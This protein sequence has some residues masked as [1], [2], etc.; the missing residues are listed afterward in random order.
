MLQLA[1]LLKDQPQSE[2]N[3]YK[4]RALKG[5]KIKD[6]ELYHKEINLLFST[7]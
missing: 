6:A 4:T 1:V 7:S 5:K 2:T 3:C